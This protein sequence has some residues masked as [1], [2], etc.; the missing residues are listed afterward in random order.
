MLGNANQETALAMSACLSHRGPD[1]RGRFYDEFEHGAVAFGHARLSIVDLEGSSQPIGSD[2]GAVLVQNGEIYNH[3][4][5]RSRYNAYPWR[6]SGDSET[7][8]AVHRKAMLSA[9]SSSYNQFADH[10]KW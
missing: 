7:I 8:L 2:H 9:E 4:K 6:T 10:A 1:G 3:S 5:L